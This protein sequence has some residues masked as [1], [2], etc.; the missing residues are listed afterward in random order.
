MNLQEAADALG[1]HYQ[2]VYRWVRSGELTATKQGTSY[3]VSATEVDRFL[4]RRAIGEPPPDRITVRDWDHHV[5]RLEALLVTGDELEARASI[6]RLADG[7]VPLVEI[8]D[9]LIAPALARVG[10]GWHEGR[11]TVA[12]EHRAT[13]ICERLL[14]RLSSHPRGRPRG[15]A[16]VLSAP[17]DEHGFPAAMA[18]MALREDRWRVHHLGTNVPVDDLLSMIKEVEAD[19]VVMSTT[20]VASA[21]TN[22]VRSMI[23]TDGVHVLVGEP[24]KRLSD[25][26]SAARATKG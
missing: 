9:E 3:E 13:A 4:L 7:N 24:G 10:M 5:D 16:V 23:E 21:A 15:V 12:E 14:A 17:G 8:C 1:V 26:V 19:L 18:A 2:T 22:E 25:L 11:I 6:D 20:I